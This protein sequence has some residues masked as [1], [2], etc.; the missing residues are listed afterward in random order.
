MS[1]VHDFEN[2]PEL[3]SFLQENAAKFNGH[4][5][6]A[7]RLMYSGIRLYESKAVSEYG[8]SGRRLRELHNE[9]PKIV[10]KEWIK[11]KDGKRSHVEYY[12]SIIPPSKQA[13]IKVGEQ[14]LQQMRDN[15]LKQGGLFE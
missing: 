1:L 8:I 10:K 3:T 14:I 7:L 5:L 2:D 13:S 9:L 12:V 6:L 4:C 15:E 11:T